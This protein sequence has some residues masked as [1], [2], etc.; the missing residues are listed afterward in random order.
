MIFAAALHLG[1]VAV[2][3]EGERRAPGAAAARSAGST[4]SRVIFSGVLAATSSMSMP[5][6]ALTMKTGRW[7]LAVHDEPDVALARDVGRR[8]HQHLLHRS[9]LICMPED[10]RRVLA[11][12]GR[13]WRQL[14]PARLAAAAGVH[15]RLDHHRCRRCAGRS[16]RPPWAWRRRRRPA[17]GCPAALSSARA[18]YSC[19]FTLA[20]LCHL[21][22]VVPASHPAA[23]PDHRTAARSSRAR[24]PANEPRGR[25]H[26]GSMLPSSSAARRD[27]ASASASVSRRQRPCGRRAP[28]RRRPPSTSVRIISTS[29]SELA[30]QDRGDAV[31]VHHRVDPFEPEQRMLDRPAARRRPPR[32]R[33]CPSSTSR[34]TSR[35]STIPGGMRAARQPAPVA[36]GASRPTGGARLAEP[37]S[38]ARAPSA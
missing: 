15:L 37:S 36:L 31:L 16:P 33:W 2:E 1:E 14:D 6:A 20:P 4:G 10:L 32:S 34:R 7:R 30:R 24:R 8:H 18:W 35:N 3:R 12:F 11:R 29:A 5:P 26:L 17:S 28:T 25:F 9:P 21:T 22:I 23:R 38:V 13:R 27:H 19:R